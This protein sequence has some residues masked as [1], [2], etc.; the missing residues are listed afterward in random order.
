MY[1]IIIIWS[2]CQF[3]LGHGSVNG[4]LFYLR[5]VVTTTMNANS[6]IRSAAVRGW[7][8]TRR[9]ARLIRDDAQIHNIII[10]Y[11]RLP[12]YTMHYIIIII[13][14]L[15]AIMTCTALSG[16]RRWP[17]IS[18]IL[19]RSVYVYWHVYT[20]TTSHIITYIIF[21]VEF[22]GCSCDWTENI[23]KSVRSMYCV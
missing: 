4:F 18:D 14:I 10:I 3:P 2:Q 5:P 16:R 15:Y 8:V 12:L 23:D 13:I 11:I 22:R 21:Y 7:L 6:F 17:R 9:G 1:T 19:Y 20:Y